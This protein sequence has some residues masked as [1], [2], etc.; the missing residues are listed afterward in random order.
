MRKT[1][2]PHKPSRHKQGNRSSCGKV[3]Q[4]GRQA[5][6]PP[7]CLPDAPIL[8]H[9]DSARCV[10]NGIIP[11]RGSGIDVDVDSRR[12]AIIC[13]VDQVPRDAEYIAAIGSD[14]AYFRVDDLKIGIGAD[15]GDVIPRLP[16][17]ILYPVAQ[18]RP[19]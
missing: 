12:G 7:A 6:A 10:Y 17:K 16:I 8:M 19:V 18:D 4:A 5:A 11:A 2:P 3:R 1:S 14:D 9:L 15:K 13:I